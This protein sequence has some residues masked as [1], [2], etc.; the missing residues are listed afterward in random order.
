MRRLRTGRALHASVAVSEVVLRSIEAHQLG[1]VSQLQ[2]GVAADGR[3]AEDMVGCER[4]GA[5]V[6]L[7]EAG[8]LPACAGLLV[9]LNGGGG[10]VRLPL[11][12]WESWPECDE[13]DRVAVCEC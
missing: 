1:F 5:I 8:R 3:G 12:Q 13:G 2:Q 11:I 4:F 7:L 10:R 6:S 9:V